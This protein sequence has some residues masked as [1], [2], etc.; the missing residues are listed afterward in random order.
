[1]EEQVRL[2][3]MELAG[4][5]D[6]TVRLLLVSTVPTQSVKEALT[7]SV[8]LRGRLADTQRELA[9][10]EQQIKEIVDDQ[11]RLRANLKEMPPTSAAYKR[12]LE[13]FDTQETDI[14]KLRTQ[15]K[16]FRESEK[17]QKTAYENYLAN[18]TIE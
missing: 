2:Q 5:D 16:Q 11:T 10:V 8:E 12:Y 17:Q 1:M 6:K 18:L 13:K 4:A 14:E 3:R 9:H 15:S 7:K